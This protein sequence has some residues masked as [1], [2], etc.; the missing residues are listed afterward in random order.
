VAVGS[1]GGHPIHDLRL[2]PAETHG[3]WARFSDVQWLWETYETTPLNN[4]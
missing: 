2:H 4:H 1:G 3:R